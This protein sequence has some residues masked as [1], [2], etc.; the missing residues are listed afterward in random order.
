MWKKHNTEPKKITLK[1]D[2]L[3]FIVLFG[4]TLVQGATFAQS[5]KKKIKDAII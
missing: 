5:A 4:I 2:L 1:K 3:L